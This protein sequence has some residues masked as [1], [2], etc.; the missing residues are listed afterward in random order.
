MIKCES[1]LNSDIIAAYTYDNNDKSETKGR[2]FHVQ[3]RV[4]LAV[5]SQVIS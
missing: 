3:V 1:K 4:N 5:N 2:L